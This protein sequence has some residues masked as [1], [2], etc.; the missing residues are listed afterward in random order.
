MAGAIVI[1]VVL[2]L[3]PVAV[4][5][6]GALAAAALGWLVKEDVDQ[7]YVGTE[8]LELGR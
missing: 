7:E 8:H 5:L 2:L 4:I 1:V 6:T 3:I